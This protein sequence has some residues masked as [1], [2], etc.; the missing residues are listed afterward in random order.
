MVMMVA[1]TVRIV[2]LI[3][4]V[5]VMMNIRRQARKLFLNC[6]AAL[7]SSKQLHAIQNIPRSSY[8]GCS[9]VLFAQECYCFCNLLIVCALCMRKNNTTCIF[10]LVIKE[11]TKV[12]HIH[13][14]LFNIRNGS[15]SIEKNFF[16]V[17]ILY[18][19]N[20]IRKLA[21]SGRLNKN[22]VGMIFI[23]NLLECF[24]KGNVF[25]RKL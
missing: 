12:L 3:L 23:E 20:N 19:A 9:G 11:L 10:D 4:I 15:K 24:S 22:A 8:N 5:V 17:Q 18:R 1:V 7:H 14:A 16:C 21:Y 25:L 2:T 6:V 13:F